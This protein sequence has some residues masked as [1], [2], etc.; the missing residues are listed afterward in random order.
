[1][2]DDPYAALRRLDAL[3][4]DL[5]L[6]TAVCMT[7]ALAYHGLGDAVPEQPMDLAAP[8]GIHVPVR[9]RLDGI[10]WHA[11]G[12]R[13]F[14]VGREEHAEGDGFPVFIYSAERAI[15]DAYRLKRYM[16][17]EAGPA[18]LARWRP[19]DDTQVG[20]LMLMAMQ[21]NATLRQLLR[22]LPSSM[23]TGKGP[24]R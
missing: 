24:D 22:D 16:G 10:A 11:F 4:P 7:S 23:A 13:S 5:Y 8:R 20:V 15:V 19:A 9:A 17:H 6:L 18:A 2:T 12:G 21:T 14:E 3:H 1:M